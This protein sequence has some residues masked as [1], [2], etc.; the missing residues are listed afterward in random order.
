MV[1]PK[2]V[3]ADKFLGNVSVVGWPTHQLQYLKLI[4][5]FKLVLLYDL[6]LKKDKGFKTEVR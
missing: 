1:L 4:C 3:A 6:C 2:V 5:V